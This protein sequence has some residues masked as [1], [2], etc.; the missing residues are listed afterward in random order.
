MVAESEA[1]LPQGVLLEI[2]FELEQGSPESI[3]IQDL[4]RSLTSIQRMVYKAELMQL[5]RDPT[6]LRKL[7]RQQRRRLALRLASRRS[8]SDI[9]TVLPYLN[10][11]IVTGMI[12]DLLAMVI[13]SIGAS[14]IGKLWNVLQPKTDKNTN[15]ETIT[16]P[17][18]E[19]EVAI[20]A[21]ALAPEI[22]SLFGRIDPNLGTTKIRMNLAAQGSDPLTVEIERDA[23]TLPVRDEMSEIGLEY[24]ESTIIRGTVTGI[25]MRD[26]EVEVEMLSGKTYTLSIPPTEISKVR[27]ASP[28]AIVVFKGVGV[29]DVIDGR[30]QL[31]SFRTDSVTIETN[32]GQHYASHQEG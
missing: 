4:T 2:E 12:G 29:Y 8:G 19:G 32:S 18:T 13:F 22:A 20:L 5:G 3:S 21:H 30:Q 7:T 28:S 1:Q 27:Y 31:R 17:I 14:G 11:P 23:R 6:D 24:E 16:S 26:N 10:D 15:S 25:S 9:Y